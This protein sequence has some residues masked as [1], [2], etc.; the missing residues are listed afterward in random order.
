MKSRRP[1]DSLTSAVEDLA[2]SLRRRREAR[3]LRIR[4]HTA[5]GSIRAVDPESDEATA[6]VEAADAL[7]S[8]APPEEP[9]P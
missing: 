7:L 2:G 8:L 4:V 1:I 3:T 6:I 9:T 5:A